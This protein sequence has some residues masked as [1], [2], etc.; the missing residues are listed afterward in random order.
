M[1]TN[2]AYPPLKLSR[3]WELIDAAGYAFYWKHGLYVNRTLRKAFSWQFMDS[4]TAE[5]IDDCVQENSQE[6]EWRF[7][8]N[9][10]PDESVREQL[11]AALE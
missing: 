10:P 1:Q 6:A 11:E 5:E 2:S 7:Y 9:E 8:F 3:K 4:H